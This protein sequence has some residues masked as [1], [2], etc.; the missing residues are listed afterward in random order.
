MKEYDEQLDANQRDGIPKL[1]QKEREITNEEI[2]TVV[3]KNSPPTKPDSLTSEFYQT[4][5]MKKNQY[6]YFLNGFF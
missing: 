4:F 3:Q 6:L 1:N 5:N 2:E